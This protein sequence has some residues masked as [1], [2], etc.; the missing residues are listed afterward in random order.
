MNQTD[1]E[2][3]KGDIN[4][5][6]GIPMMIVRDIVILP[7]TS[8]HFDIQRE[9]SINAVNRALENDEP[10]LVIMAREQIEEGNATKEQLYSAGSVVQ[11]K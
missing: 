6:Y 10:V 9:A 7:G 11:V 4:N 5:I 3:E 2:L 1:M 8:I